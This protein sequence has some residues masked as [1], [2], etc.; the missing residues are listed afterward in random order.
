MR[1]GGLEGGALRGVGG[2]F[3]VEVEGERVGGV[4]AGAVR[5][6]VDHVGDRVGVSWLRFV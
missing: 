2:T 4:S 3:I 6:F 1:Q 5:P